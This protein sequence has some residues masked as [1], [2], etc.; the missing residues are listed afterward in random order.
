MIFQT[1]AEATGRN[2]QYLDLVDQA[3]QGHEVDFG[4]VQRRIAEKEEEIKSHERAKQETAENVER[5][6]SSV[7]VRRRI[8]GKQPREKNGEMDARSGLS[9][10]TT[11]GTI[12]VFFAQ[13]CIASSPSR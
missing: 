13:P 10:N 4:L 12:K 1:P 2:E 7:H 8:T 5:T 11:N 3:L 9:K 6:R